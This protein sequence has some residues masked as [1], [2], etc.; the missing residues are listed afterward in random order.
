MSDSNPFDKLLN[1]LVAE[2]LALIR[3]RVST[4]LV[5][6]V[7]HQ[8]KT[9]KANELRRRVIMEEED[10]FDEA[11]KP[12]KS[13]PAAVCET[14]RADRRGRVFT[15]DELAIQ[16]RKLNK[17]REE[18]KREREEDQQYRRLNRGKENWK[19]E[20]SDDLEDEEE[21]NSDDSLADFVVDDHT[22][23]R[24]DIKD[25]SRSQASAG[26]SSYL[27]NFVDDE[28]EEGEEEVDDHVSDEEEELYIRTKG[29]KDFYESE[30]EEEETDDEDENEVVRAGGRRQR[31]RARTAG[32]VLDEVDVEDD[33][34]ISADEDHEENQDA[35][36]SDFVNDEPSECWTTSQFESPSP[37]QRRRKRKLLESDDDSDEAEVIAQVNLRAS[38]DEVDIKRPKHFKRR[39][40]PMFDDSDDNDEQNDEP[41]KATASDLRKKKLFIISDDESDI[42]DV[43]IVDETVLKSSN[44]KKIDVC[45]SQPDR[46]D[47][48]SID[49]IS[50]EQFIGNDASTE[51]NSA[52]NEE[53][54]DMA[55]A[56]LITSLGNYYKSSWATSV[57]QQGSYDSTKFEHF[58][59]DDLDM[60][61]SKLNAVQ[62][63]KSTNP[64]LNTADT[65][66]DQVNL[67]ERD[68]ENIFDSDLKSDL[69]DDSIDVILDSSSDL[70]DPSN[71]SFTTS[72]LNCSRLSERLRRKEKRRSV[73]NLVVYYSN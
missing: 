52:N 73:F 39:I 63:P 46:L 71:Q 26:N 12:V 2:P 67:T 70:I 66:T 1:K 62:T 41:C 51:Y 34:L 72:E 8:S 61:L 64:P 20:D 54:K 60:K 65:N 56:E 27:L 55:K 25:S 43:S 53:K 68:V 9:A 18:L 11:A 57:N 6:K 30:D 7:P 59:T 32:F 13:V 58:Q 42:A 37:V 47:E 10:S 19:I 48:M 49:N 33:D 22:I 17:Y 36:E 40:H 5:A 29:I 23:D 16:K 69:F 31:R 21:T 24:I 15:Y 50:N 44:E 38:D 14:K 28:C 45:S 4:P 3:A 35:Y